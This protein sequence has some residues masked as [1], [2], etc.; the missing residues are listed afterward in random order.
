MADGSTK[1]IQNIKIG[2]LI[3]NPATG[4]DVAVKNIMVGEQKREMYRIHYDG[5]TVSATYNHPFLTSKGVLRA[6][7][8]RAGDILLNESIKRI[9]VEKIEII[10]VEKGRLVWNL[11]LDTKDSKY[12]EIN[13]H[14]FIANGLATGDFYLQNNNDKANQSEF[15]KFQQYMDSK[16]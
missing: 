10:P 9:P 2:D 1:N 3:R 15:A 7:E 8:L 11:L 6:E 14:L 4:M 13:N 16:K 5:K 12:I